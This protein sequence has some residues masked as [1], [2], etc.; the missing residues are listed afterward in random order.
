[1]L[2]AFTVESFKPARHY[3]EIDPGGVIIT[4]DMARL[5]QVGDFD[6]SGDSA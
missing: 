6:G 5:N 2:V 1:M 4:S 3:I